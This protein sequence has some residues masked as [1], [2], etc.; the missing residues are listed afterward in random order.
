MIRTSRIVFS[1]ASIVIVTL[2]GACAG[3]KTD[4][5]IARERANAYLEQHPQTDQSIAAMIRANRLMTGMTE[6]QVRA[7]WGNPVR[8]QKFRNGTSQVWDFGCDFPH[9]CRGGGPRG[10]RTPEQ[11]INSRAHFVDGKLTEWRM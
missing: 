9:M 5:Q 2:L 8:V 10:R 7:A 4:T 1:V 6:A 3:V 11:T